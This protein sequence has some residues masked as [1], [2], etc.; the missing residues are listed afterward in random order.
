MAI[1]FTITVTGH[2]LTKF[3]RRDARGN[4]ELSGFP[5]QTKM[6]FPLLAAGCQP[7]VFQRS[8]SRGTGRRNGEMYRDLH[9]E[10]HN[11]GQTTGAP[12][13]YSPFRVSSSHSWIKKDL[14]L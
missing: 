10:N 14:D 9:N 4:P 8:R 7:G 12:G 2:R 3:R 1:L 11:A 6:C 5:L 13:C